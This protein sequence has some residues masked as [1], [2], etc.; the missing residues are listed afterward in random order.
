MTRSDDSQTWKEIAAQPQIWSE[1]G[2][3][4][5]GRAAEVRDWIVRPGIEEIVFAGTG[6]SAFIGEIVSFAPPR[7]GNLRAIPTT[8]IVSCPFECLRDDPRLLVAQFGR[9]GDSSE[10]V[11]VLELLDSLFPRA[12]GLNIACNPIGP[13]ATRPAGSHGAQR[14]LVLPSATHDRG[15]AMT[16]SFTTMLLSAMACLD[17]EIDVASRLADLSRQVTGLIRSLGR[18]SGLTGQSFSAPALQRAWR[19]KARLRGSS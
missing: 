4:L 3:R 12:Q 1:W 7:R 14:T 9:S 18:R 8:D 17:A 5:A 19:A 15:L 13:P 16:S 2:P 11:G 6:S 10:T